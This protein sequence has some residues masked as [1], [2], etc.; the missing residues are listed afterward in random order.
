MLVFVAAVVL[1]AHE[2]TGPRTLPVVPDVFG[3]PI[4]RH[5]RREGGEIG[6]V[7]AGNRVPLAGPLV[8]AHRFTASMT[9][10]PMMAPLARFEVRRAGNAAEKTISF[11]CAK[12]LSIDEFGRPRPFGEHHDPAAVGGPTQ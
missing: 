8:T 7:R 11:I 10:A 5:R 4:D 1:A 6:R 9:V 12:P 3:R 2:P